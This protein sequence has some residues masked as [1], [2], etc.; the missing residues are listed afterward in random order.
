MLPTYFE[1]AIEI[2]KPAD[3]TD[4]QCMSIWAKYGSGT[5]QEIAEK[6]MVI[7]PAVFESVD[8]DNFRYFLTAWQPSKEDIE[9]INRGEPIYVKT[10]SAGLPPM[11]LFVVHQDAAGSDT[12]NQ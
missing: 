9:A 2:K 5:L 10:L 3:M 11:A 4:E 6:N 1:G 7:P 12:V 8:Q